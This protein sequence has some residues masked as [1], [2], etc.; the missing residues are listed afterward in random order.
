LNSEED[1]KIFGMR[2]CISDHS[3]IRLFWIG[4][5]VS[6][7]RL[8]SEIKDEE[9]DDYNQYLLDGKVRSVCHRCDLEFLILCASSRMM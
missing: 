7:R 6:S 8:A 5:P 4:V 2:K 9:T 3:S 1:S